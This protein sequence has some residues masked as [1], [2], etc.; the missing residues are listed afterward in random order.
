ML[1]FIRR[2]FEK[3][4]LGSSPSY[5]RLDL[6]IGVTSWRG[7]VVLAE[8]A[9]VIFGLLLWSLF[10]PLKLTVKGNGILQ[11]GE[12][13]PLQAGMD[14]TVREIHVSAGQQ[15]IKGDKAFTLGFGGLEKEI[16]LMS[17]QLANLEAYHSKTSAEEADE[18]KR[19]E[20]ALGETERD[21]SRN[22]GQMDERIAGL[23]R[24][25]RKMKGSP[26]YAGPQIRA[27]EGELSQLTQRRNS[28]N[29]RIAESAARELN[30]LK[31]R[32]REASEARLERMSKLKSELDAK[33]KDKSDNEIV[34]VPE[35]GTV[36]EI[37]IA[38]GEIV[39][40][41][42]TLARLEEAAAELEAVAYVPAK[43]A[44][45]IGKKM[46]G[47][48]ARI[49]LDSFPAEKYG[50]LLAQADLDSISFSPVSPEK[51]EEVVRNKALVQ[52]LLKKGTLY[53]VRAKLQ[54]DESDP[55]GYRWSKFLGFG[56]GPGQPLASGAT[57]TGKFEIE[58]KSPITYVIPKVGKD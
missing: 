50:S 40:R 33:E 22:I 13:K 31:S 56:G 29:M 20:F 10:W 52:A 19:K 8:V 14:G 21:L 5:E 27:V 35:S 2:L 15:V 48:P 38:Q 28:A 32:Y 3:E 7:W 37:S 17:K 39:S 23:N 57:V 11:R 54:G 41:S 42:T 25:L 1:G 47:A 34:R 58:R 6:L 53:E 4:D 30:D 44:A 51:V 55:S 36:F 46:Q 18:I 43:D 24:E 16:M 9:L 26:Y 49:S 12:P 45:K